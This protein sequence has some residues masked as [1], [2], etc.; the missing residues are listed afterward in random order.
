MTQGFIYMSGAIISFTASVL[1]WLVWT[2]RVRLSLAMEVGMSVTALGLWLCAISVFAV[3]PH[4]TI[5]GW[6]L[7]GL[8]SATVLI[9]GGLGWTV[10][11]V[12]IKHSRTGLRLRRKSDFM[13]LDQSSVRHGPPL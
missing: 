11:S 6:D 3:Q 12:A 7:Q 4:S 2:Q 13:E 9:S 8:V 5:D 10:L 1:T